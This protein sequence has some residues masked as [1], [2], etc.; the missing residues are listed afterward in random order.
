ML[1]TESKHKSKPRTRGRTKMI[2]G[3]TTG[4]F[5]LFHVGHIRILKKA[6]SLCDRLIV[7]VSTDALV[8]EAKNKMPI[9]PFE[10]RMETVLACK[11]ADLVVPQTSYDKMEAWKHYKFNLMFVG[12]D[13]QGTDKWNKLEEDFQK[14]GV[15]IIYFPYTSSTSSTIITE[16]LRQI[17]E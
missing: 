16:K 14:V 7:G 5:D 6:K 12:D 4:V 8:Q 1:K 10:E 11:Y 2:I 9:I 17:E 13:W 3:Y 15:Q